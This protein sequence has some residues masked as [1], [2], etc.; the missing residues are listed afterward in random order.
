MLVEISNN[1]DTVENLKKKRGIKAVKAEW[2]RKICI[3]EE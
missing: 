1:P 3:S 2:K